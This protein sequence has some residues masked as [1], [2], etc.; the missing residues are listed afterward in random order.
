VYLT[1]KQPGS[2]TDGLLQN[3][4]GDAH[5]ASDTKVQ[6]Y[7]RIEADKIQARSGRDVLGRDVHVVPGTGLDIKKL[8]ARFGSRLSHFTGHRFGH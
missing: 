1:A 2:S 8:G 6:G 7:V 3:N 4:Y 5:T